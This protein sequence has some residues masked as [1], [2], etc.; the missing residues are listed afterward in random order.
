MARTHSLLSRFAAAFACSGRR[1]FDA[2]PCLAMR[3]PA[4]LRGAGLVGRVHQKGEVICISHGTNFCPSATGN[5]IGNSIISFYRG[6]DGTTCTPPHGPLGRA[7]HRSYFASNHG[8]DLPRG[9]QACVASAPGALRDATPTRSRGWVVCATRFG[10]PVG[11]RQAIA[12]QSPSGAHPGIRSICG[13]HVG[14]AVDRASKAKLTVL[15]ELQ[16]TKAAA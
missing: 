3:H 11:R 7:V 15:E 14:D 4:A 12:A 9:R 2:S 13:Q 5:S 8:K 6:S 10:L 1:F 16:A